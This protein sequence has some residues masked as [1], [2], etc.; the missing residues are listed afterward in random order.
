M[1]YTTADLLSIIKKRAYVPNAQETLDDQDLLD[2]ATDEMHSMIVPA[3]LSTN[4]EWYVTPF[5]TTITADTT[6]LDIH[7]RS[8]GGSLRDVTFVTGGSEHGLTRLNLEDKSYVTNQGAI[9][10]F[11]VQGN[12]LKLMGAQDGEIIQYFHA[13]PGR[14]VTTDSCARIESVDVANKLLTVDAIPSTW[15]V[16]NK[17]DVIKSNPHF[18]YRS[19]SLTITNIA[20]GAIEV[21]ETPSSKIVV[22]D[23]VSLED[24]SPVPQIPVEWFQ[25]LA[26]TVVTQVLNNQS[27]FDAGKISYAKSEQLRNAA[28]SLMSPRIVGELKK[29]V[30]P[31]NRGSLTGLRSR[32]W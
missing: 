16:G 18:E 13:R 30:S 12:Q 8:I 2:M 9:S 27:D 3:V 19:I 11:Y 28:I 29:A 20:G 5:S 32:G 1:S 14:L 26:Q 25:Y 23:W 21:A 22:G 10:G 15:V 7:S 17:I 6:E 4:Q 31:K 24:T